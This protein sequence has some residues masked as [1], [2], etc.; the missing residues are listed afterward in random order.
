MKQFKGVGCNQREE[1]L[2]TQLWI[3]QAVLNST[4]C[5]PGKSPSNL[6]Q[7]C[8]TLEDVEHIIMHC[9]K[10]NSERE[11]QFALAGQE[12]SLEALLSTGQG[13]RDIR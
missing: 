4:L 11:T 10:Y 8:N 5:L 7:W 13:S 9:G 1:V 3:G 12:W 2:F 6:C